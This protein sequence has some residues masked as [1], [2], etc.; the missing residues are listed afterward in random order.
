MQAIHCINSMYLVNNPP[1]AFFRVGLVVDLV[2]SEF[3][4]HLNH[5]FFLISVMHV[6]G[7]EGFA[8][9]ICLRLQN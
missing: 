3:E 9:S 4:R 6:Y 1:N 8:V 2:S 7:E 5:I